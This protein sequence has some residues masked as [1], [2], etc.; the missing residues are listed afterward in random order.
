MKEAGERRKLHDEMFNY[1]FFSQ[2]I[3]TY[4]GNAKGKVVPV[5]S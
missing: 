2:Y 1:P 3:V 5:L 4:P